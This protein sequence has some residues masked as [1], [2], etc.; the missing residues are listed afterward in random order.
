MKYGYISPSSENS[1]QDEQDYITEGLINL[2]KDAGLKETGVMDSATT[3]LI[4]TPRCGVFKHFRSRQKRFTTKW[5]WNTIKNR[6]NETMLTWYLD[7][8][9]FDDIQS[10]NLTKRMIKTIMTTVTYKWS[11]IPLIRFKQ[12]YDKD[13][14]NITIKF[15]KGNHSDGYD[16]DG[17]GKVLAHAFYPGGGIGGDIHFDLDE[18]WT[19]WGEETG[20]SLFTVALHEMGHSLGLGHSSEQES[21]MYAWYR[22]K[23]INLTEDDIQGINSLY[24]ARPTTTTTTRPTTRPTTTTTT[25]PTTT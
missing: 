17:P 4:Q 7:L 23:N 1:L 13:S 25:R 3:Y 14:S 2:Q 8:S 19:L 15:L 11:K 10:N 21:I 18:T 12:V 24:S 9:N 22:P 16:F 5:R 6:L 20:N